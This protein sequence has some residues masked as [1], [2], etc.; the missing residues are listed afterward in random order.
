M[1]SCS[2]YVYM[3]NYVLLSKIFVSKRAEVLEFWRKLR[4]VYFRDFDFSPNFNRVIK[5]SRKMIG[6]GVVVYTKLA[7]L[8]RGKRSVRDRI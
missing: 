2:D 3:H 7:S 5:K 6:M 8:G 1:F 4:N